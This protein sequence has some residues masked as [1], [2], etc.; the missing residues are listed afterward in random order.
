MGIQREAGS[1]GPCRSKAATCIAHTCQAPEDASLQAALLMASEDGHASRWSTVRL[2]QS[3][4]QHCTWARRKSCNINARLDPK[5]NHTNKEMNNSN[6]L[7]E[8][9]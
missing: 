9:K 5:G 1:P 7:G 6:V 3:Q 4:G 8:I 2:P